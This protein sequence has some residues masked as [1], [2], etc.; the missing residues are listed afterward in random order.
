MTFGRNKLSMFRKSLFVALNLTTLSSV[1]HCEKTA[2]FVDGMTGRYADKQ[3]GMK[4]SKS[5]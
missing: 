1:F 4:G 5:G 2:L 3:E